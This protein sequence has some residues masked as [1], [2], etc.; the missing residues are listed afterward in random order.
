MSNTSLC[1]VL[2]CMTARE[3]LGE[4]EITADRDITEQDFLHLCPAI[5]F[6]VC[7]TLY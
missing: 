2:Q 7:I 3:I 6:Q 5:V 1:F 4:F